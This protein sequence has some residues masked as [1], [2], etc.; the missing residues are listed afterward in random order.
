MKTPIENLTHEQ[1]IIVIASL[2]S[3]AGWCEISRKSAMSRGDWEIAV[4]W[5]D[6]VKETT[7][8]YDL[9]TKPQTEEEDSADVCQALS[10]V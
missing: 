7:R 8:L 2:N 1:Y 5:A 4:R 3:Y 9:F 10:Q 6:K